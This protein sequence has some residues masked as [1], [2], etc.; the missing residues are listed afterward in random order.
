MAEMVSHHSLLYRD[1]QNPSELLGRGSGAALSQYWHYAATTNL[2]SRVPSQSRD[3][4][5]YSALMSASQPMIVDQVIDAYRFDEHRRVLDVGGGNGTFLQAIGQRY[6][7][8]SLAVFDLPAVVEEQSAENHNN[9]QY[10][11]GD[12]IVDDLPAG[13]DLITLVR[14]LHDHNDDA[15]M[16]LLN[17]VFD[18][19]APGTRLMIAEPMA[20]TQGTSRMA[21]AYFNFYFLAMGK[22][23]PRSVARLQEMLVAAGF[24]NP[25]HLKTTLPLVCSI[26]L[27]EKPAH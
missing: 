6:P 7:Q 25:S 24:S 14:I 5:A 10:I 2:Q 12:F 11:A 27:A 18:A 26:L 21:D 17:N 4:R 8:L 1:L 13:Y 22:G 15:V 3:V 20:P 9:L 23:E 16:A 19:A